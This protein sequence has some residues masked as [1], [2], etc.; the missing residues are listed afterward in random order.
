MSD[1]FDVFSVG[2]IIGIIA[3]IIF[4][5]SIIYSVDFNIESKTKTLTPYKTLIM[6]SDTIYFFREIEGE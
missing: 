1:K 4:F 5:I 3:T 2:L 6:G